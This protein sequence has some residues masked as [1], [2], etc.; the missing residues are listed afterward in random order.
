MDMT[1]ELPS[2]N[3]CSKDQSNSRSVLSPC[4]FKERA[5][6]LFLQEFINANED[7]NCR[8][9]RYNVKKYGNINPNKLDNSLNHYNTSDLEPGCSL[10]PSL[11]RQISL[12]TQIGS[13]AQ[14]SPDGVG[15]YRNSALRTLSNLFIDTAVRRRR[16]ITNG[17]G[18]KHDKYVPTSES[19]IAKLPAG[20]I[21]SSP[22]LEDDASITVS[23]Q[24]PC[25]ALRPRNLGRRGPVKETIANIDGK[26]LLFHGGPIS[27][28]CR[29]QHFMPGKDT[30]QPDDFKCQSCIELHNLQPGASAIHHSDE[31]R[32]F[33]PSTSNS[34]L[35][36]CPDRLDEFAEIERDFE[37]EQTE[38][39]GDL[40]A[41]D[42]LLSSCVEPK[43]STVF[44]ASRL[45]M[46]RPPPL[47]LP[48]AF[49]F[50]AEMNQDHS[51]SARKT[52][53]TPDSRF[54][55]VAESTQAHD[56][57]AD[58]QSEGSSPYFIRPRAN[59]NDTSST[60]V[61]PFTPLVLS[62]PYRS[63]VTGSMNRR[64]LMWRLGAFNNFLQ[65]SKQTEE[66]YRQVDNLS[67]YRPY[68]T[69]MLCFIHVLVMVFACSGYGFAPIGINLERLVTKQL[70]MPSLDTE[71]VC[72]IQDEN[73]WIG[74]Q[75]ADLIRMGARF[76]PC[77][78]FDETL[79]KVVV[80]AQKNW[81]RRSGCCIRSEDGIC[82]QTSRLFCS[83]ST[84][85]W[86]H[87]SEANGSPVAQAIFDPKIRGAFRDGLL[88]YPS[89][90]PS[91]V[92]IG[93]VC[94][95]DPEFCAEPR[96]TGPFAWSQHDVTEWPV[97]AE[98]CTCFML[99]GFYPTLWSLV[100][101]V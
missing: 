97:R 55:Q 52:P 42:A 21:V 47:N 25:N 43:V 38:G 35:S 36:K 23:R 46:L 39:A 100:A 92:P 94:G 8:R 9:I 96:S 37:V 87:Y 79:N 10:T 88:P 62:K 78:R 33:F 4:T 95:L 85:T 82:Y 99:I 80:E 101:L 64:R 77:M 51:P 30:S 29:C 40:A 71:N 31:R 6:A 1:K 32:F 19:V 57:S 63:A 12:M 41:I 27:S 75:Q 26:K 14:F 17:L 54:N 68:F 16:P 86:L 74:P 66:I 58:A 15:A 22:V 81:D 89:S 59:H 93:P 83:R 60:P 11:K 5:F 44:R 56:R 45:S 84:S 28:P 48:S 24:S 18:V 70:M 53:L 50:T 49:N 72:R 90:L 67:D 13:P 34:Q 91:R 61:S 3:P 65:R 98:M 76:S 73:I 2:H 69:Y 7:W 20:I